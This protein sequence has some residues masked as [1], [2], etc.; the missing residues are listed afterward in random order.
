[1]IPLYDM[2]FHTALPEPIH[3]VLAVSG[4]IG[5]RRHSLGVPCWMNRKDAV[6]VARSRGWRVVGIWSEKH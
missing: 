4:L 3:A 1:M 5:E 6:E 2:T